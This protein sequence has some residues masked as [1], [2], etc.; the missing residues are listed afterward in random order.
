MTSGRK[1]SDLTSVGNLQVGDILVGERTTGT[2]VRITYNGAVVSDGDKGDITVSGSG[3]TWTVDNAAITY[4]KIQ[5]VSAT[6]R[7][8]GRNTAG[9][10]SIEEL[11]S[12]TVKTMLSLDLVENTAL[13]TWSGSTNL[14]T[15]GT[16]ATGTWNATVVGVAYGG[17]GKTSVTAY[18]PIVGGTTSTGAL[19]STTSG[20]TGQ[21]LQSAGST[22]IPTWSTPTYPSSSGTARK[23]LVSDGTNNVYSTETWAVPGTSGHILQSDGTNW[24]SA[25]PTGTGTPVLATSPTLATPLLGT[26]TSGTLTN[27]TGLPL[28]TGITGTLPVANGGSGMPARQVVGA[29]MSVDQTLTNITATKLT[30]DTEEFDTSGIYDNSTNYR[31]QPTIASKYRVSFLAT[32]DSTGYVS[33]YGAWIN[34]YKNGSAF[35]QNNVSVL[36][37]FNTSATV[38]AVIDFNGSTDYIE[39]WALQAHG[40]NSKVLGG[41][42]NTYFSIEPI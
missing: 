12:T 42:G 26:P 13:S 37:G 20:S 29:Y 28:T 5:D 39:F 36:A 31:V 22:S 11:T 9:A 25:T 16:I 6:A 7:I 27:C 24:T 19:Q 32:F 41:Q 14:T 2:T 8:L 38:T 17:T 35:K 15:L 1:V 10:G 18:A 34:I 23:I 21:I 33:N 40:S 3:T 30:I 4:A